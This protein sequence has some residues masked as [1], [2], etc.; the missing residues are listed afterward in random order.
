MAARCSTRW[1]PAVG[2]ASAWWVA[3]DIA[4]LVV[5]IVGEVAAQPLDIDVAGAHHGDG[6]LIVDQR[7]Q[8]VLERRVFVP[9]L[10]GE[11]RARCRVCSR[12]G[13]SIRTLSFT[14][15]AYRHDGRTGRHSFSIVH[16]SGCW[17]R[18]AKSIIWVTLVSATS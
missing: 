15:P 3:D 18:R 13:D 5:D 14:R 1:K 2:L 4:E 10:V 8:Q 9:P 6:V 16:C 11:A 12:F 17:C 7:Q